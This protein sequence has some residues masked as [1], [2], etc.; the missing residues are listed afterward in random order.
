MQDIRIEKLAKN[1]LSHSINLQKNENILI[2]ILGEDAI[3]LGKELIKQ[4]EL[5]GANPFLNIINYGELRA[6]N[7]ENL[8]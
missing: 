4:A 8:K 3:P 2:E 6:L 1:L 5:M 7:P